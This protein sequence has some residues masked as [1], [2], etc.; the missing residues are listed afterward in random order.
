MKGSQAAAA[1]WLR[2]AALP[3]VRF[4]GLVLSDLRGS[5]CWV[6]V[7]RE[8]VRS[9]LPTVN[10]QFPGPVCSDLPEGRDT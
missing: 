10:S 8:V 2:E 6:Y 1:L 4:C 3:E 9:R 7:G 5:H